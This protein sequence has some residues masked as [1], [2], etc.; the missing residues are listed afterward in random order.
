[1]RRGAPVND[2]VWG[3]PD[4]AALWLP[5]QG[6]A[7]LSVCVSGAMAYV[8]IDCAAE[9]HAVC[10][11]DPSGKGAGS[12][13]IASSAPGLGRLVCKI[14][15]LG[16]PGVMAVAIERPS[17]R[18]VDGYA[19][20]T[21]ALRIHAEAWPSGTDNPHGIGILARAWICVI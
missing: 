13:T 20:E 2:R 18:L 6:A 16:D 5:V 10:V 12:F 14:A 7:L 3:S 1:M 15:G 19:E 4:V 8:A 11:I 9:A 17:S 21:K